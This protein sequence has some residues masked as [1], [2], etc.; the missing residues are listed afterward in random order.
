MNKD[1]ESITDTRKKVVIT[2]TAEE[3]AKEE[4]KVLSTFVNQ[5]RIPGFRKGKAP[6]PMIRKKFAKDI[7][8][9]L[10]RN[11]GSAAYEAI[12]KDEE[13]KLYRLLNIN[14]EKVDIET[15]AEAVLEYDIVP[16]FELPKFSEFSYEAGSSEATEEDIEKAIE[17]MR[18][19]RADFQVVERAAVKG[20]YVKCSYEGKIG[21]QLVSELVS[22]KPIYGTQASTWEEAGSED[23]PRIQAIADG[24]VGMS[25]GDKKEI[26]MSYPADFEVEALAGKDVTYSVEVTEIR[27][28]V[29][30]ELDDEFF[31]SIQVESLEALKEKTA[32]EMKQQRE[33]SNKVKA[34][35][36]ISDEIRNAIDFELPLSGV[37]DQR[38]AYLHELMERKMREG[39]TQE[40][41]EEQKDELVAEATEVAKSRLKLSLILDRIGE[42]EKIQADKNDFN[43]AIMQEAYMN[44]IQPEKLVKELSKD[45]ARIAQL[46]NDIIRSKALDFVLEQAT[47]IE[48]T[49]P[50]VASAEA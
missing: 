5:A 48:A 7:S 40:Q 10:E 27:A 30:P 13:S 39:S 29:L 9:E 24:V 36:K 8:G 41:L 46:R 33:Y 23:G 35:R 25:T 34:R 16:S 2:F 14:I 44:R 17:H 28:K 43:S 22:D 1:I 4:K 37:E 3:V 49:E 21:D 38:D 6:L 42:V 12:S 11:I 19:Q 20:D 50:E 32:T 47:K 15:G 18:S 31:K 45:R 26:V